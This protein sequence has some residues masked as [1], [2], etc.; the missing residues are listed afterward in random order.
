MAEAETLNCPMC[1][2]AATSNSPRCEHCGAQLAT[3]A[4]PSCFG[5]MFLGQKFCPHCGARADRTELAD[6][7]RR[8]CPRCRVQMEAAEVG[9]AKLR[10]CP[11][12][13]GIWVDADTLKEICADRED[14]AAV[15]GMANPVTPSDSNALEQVRYVPCPVCRKLMN[16]VQFAHCSHVVVDVCSLHGTWFDQDELRRIVEFIRGGGL[17]TARRREIDELEEQRRGLEAART[18][19]SL[20]LP[21][22]SARPNYDLVDLGVSA[23]ATFLKGLFK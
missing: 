19:A 2:A 16:R 12:C 13:Q 21:Q 1:G 6:A 15:L 14:Q 11:R 3:V 18:S 8:L 4:C 5:M 9:K 10:E 7:T 17:E 20:D 23:A 22:T